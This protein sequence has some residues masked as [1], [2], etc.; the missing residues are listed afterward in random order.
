MD[1]QFERVYTI[2]DWYDGPRA[3]VAD[4]RGVPHFYRSVYLDSSEWNSDEDRF[5]LTPLSKELFDWMLE[6]D[7]LF[8]RWDT[9]RRTRAVAADPAPDELRI[10]PE[11]R[12]RYQLLESNIATAVAASRPIATMRG[13]FEY[14]PN[15]V[16]WM[17]VPSARPHH[18]QPQN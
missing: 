6:A 17:P 10:L 14:N 16:R 18:D 1:S 5:E 4:F 8:Q 3:G 15:R 7:A 2:E 13:Q 11:D 12:S 9:A